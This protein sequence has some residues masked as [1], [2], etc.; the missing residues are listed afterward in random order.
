[1]PIRIDFLSNVR[2]LLRGT[3]QAEDAFDDVADSLDDVARDGDQALGRLE[4]S[5]R[6]VARRAKTTSDE[7][8]RDQRRMG[9]RSAE[10]GQEIRQ[11]LG[12]GIANAARGDFAS[13]ADTIG[14]TLGGAV[15]GIGGIGTA[16]L[17]VAGAFGLGAIVAAF[18]G[19]QAEQEKLREETNEWA[20]GYIEAGSTVLGA[21]QLT[22]NGLRILSERHAELEENARNWGVSEEVALRAMAGA[23]EA[24]DFVAEALD[25][26]RAAAA[27]DAAEAARLAEANGG[28]LG[29]L[30]PMEQEVLKGQSA[31]DKQRQA[32]S[33]AAAQADLYSRYL[34]GL[35]NDSSA[36]TKE[37]D[38]LGNTLYT[39]P[40]GKQILVDA[41]TGQ[42]TDNVDKFKGD[43]DGIPETVTSTVKFHA[44][45]RAVD[46]ARRRLQQKIT[47]GVDAIV[48]PGQ[49]AW[50]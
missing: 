23:P 44:D 19:I 29:S 9:E 6:D 35:V 1:M 34:I 30:T 40:D 7:V 33:D 25:R 10:V 36:A 5:F 39:L 48:R 37:V 50:Q 28:V 8:V 26:K 47:I 46:D 14:D 38:E 16:A 41:Q 15:A 24:L 45:T 12:E 20:K 11:N 4:R 3:K 32:M 17:G 27:L 2:D 42:A 21:A 22:A 49:V 31:L 43:L 13:L 18:Q